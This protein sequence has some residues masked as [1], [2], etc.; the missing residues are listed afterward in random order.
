MTRSR[1]AEQAEMRA[2]LVAVGSESTRFRAV[3]S[4]VDESE[5]PVCGQLGVFFANRAVVESLHSIYRIGE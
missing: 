4:M 1:F 3:T 2:N 5:I